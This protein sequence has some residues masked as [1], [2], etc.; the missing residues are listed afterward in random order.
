MTATELIPGS[1]EW[2]KLIT[3][4]KVA[5]IL[6]VSKYDSPRSMWHKMRG[7]VDPEPATTV[8]TRGHYLEPAVLQWFFDQ[9][10]ELYPTLRPGT[11]VHPN[12]W[13][14]ATPD[15]LG[16]NADEQATVAVEAKTS[17]DDAEWGQPG[18]DE[19]PLTYTAQCMWTMHV[20][21]LQRIYV[22]VLSS[23]LEFREYVVEYDHAL[24]VDIEATCL[25][26]LASLKGNVAPA[27]DSH[28][29]TYQTLRRANPLI[30][31]GLE[32]QLTTEQAR[33]F[34]RSRQDK[35]AADAL[36]ALA[37][38]TIAEAM[39]DA[40][41]AYWGT[42]LVARRQNTASDKPAIY[43]AKKLPTITETSAAA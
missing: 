11:H 34:V 21:G 28:P 36:I 17:A 39:G 40:Q 6:G 9:H 43:P 3:A 5:A 8:Q 37:N 7:D 4:S 30:Q 32:V 23:Y 16:H 15:A 33:L 42:Q 25:E 13:A 38:S 22:P 2:L 10:P 1:P 14:A 41:K 18:T 27:V 35:A 24:A 31:Q 29:E 19:I 12:G 26:F 20:L